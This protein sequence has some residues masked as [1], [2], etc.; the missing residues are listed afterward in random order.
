MGM[1]QFVLTIADADDL[2]AS[3]S[4]DVVA[5]RA[6]HQVRHAGQEPP[7]R[8]VGGFDPAFVATVDLSCSWQPAVLARL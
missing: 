3:V 4:L 8:G 6:R 7:A 1:M 2:G 5:A